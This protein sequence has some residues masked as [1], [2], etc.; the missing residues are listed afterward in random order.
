M[1]NPYR[2]TLKPTPAGADKFAPWFI[3][4]LSL[5]YP[6]RYAPYDFRYQNYSPVVKVH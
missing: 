2:A 4:Q 6:E 5:S 3:T 1:S